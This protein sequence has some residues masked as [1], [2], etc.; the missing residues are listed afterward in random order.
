MEYT[1]TRSKRRTVALYIR[2]GV[3]EVRAPLKMPKAMID[4]FVA[5]K[6]KWAADKLV[7]SAR[8][9][10]QRESFTLAYGDCVLYRGRPYPI[11]AREGRRAGFDSEGFYLPPDLP[12][13][14]IKAACVKIY[15]MLAKRDL[16]ERALR[17]AGQMSVAPATVKI[18]GAKTRW[19]S[20]SGR[21][22]LNFSWRLIMAADDVIDYV[23][24]HELA[25]LTEMNHSARFW[26]IV[27]GVLPGYRKQRAK[28]KELQHRLDGED[29]E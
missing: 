23:V 19:G 18:N 22:S 2:D 17:F 27:E 4:E 13:G 15:R 26:A 14:Q 20:C 24:V 29:W 11:T 1:L 28:L 6:E 12:P 16:T 10:E 9:L 7:A 3:L 8:R 21:K 25:H 5:S